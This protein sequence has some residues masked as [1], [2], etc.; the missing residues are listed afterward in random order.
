MLLSSINVQNAYVGCGYAALIV[1]NRSRWEEKYLYIYFYKYK[2]K[3]NRI[4]KKHTHF[5]I[6]T[7]HSQNENIKKK[8]LN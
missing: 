3:E 7:L 6:S 1:L 5:F 8:K 4:S 2:T